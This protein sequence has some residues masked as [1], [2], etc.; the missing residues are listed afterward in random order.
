M[1]KTTILFDGYDVRDYVH[2]IRDI[3]RGLFAPRQI[4][5]QDIDGMD[6]SY[7]VRARSQSRPIEFVVTLTGETKSELR[8]QADLLA[9]ILLTERPVPIQITDEPDM[10]Y[11]GIVADDGAF[12][13]LAKLGFATINILCPDPYKYGPERVV[14]FDSTGTATVVFA[15][16]STTT[17]RATGRSNPVFEATF[18][19]AQSNFEIWNDTTGEFVRI[20]WNFAIGDVLVVDCENNLIKINGVIQKQSMTYTSVFIDVN[21]G[22]TIRL[23][24]TSVANVDMTFKPRWR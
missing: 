22:D 19:S 15:G 9:D 13:E 8:D 14:T 17:A 21:H 10:T 12:D 16:N 18:T 1:A 2:N 11:F 6:G 5:T 3:K 4:K 23:N 7:F 24:P 20:I